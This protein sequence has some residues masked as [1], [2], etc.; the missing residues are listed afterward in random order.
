MVDGLLITRMRNL[1]I[2]ILQ[3]VDAG[4]PHLLQDGAVVG[5]LITWIAGAFT[6]DEEQRVP[7]R[8]KYIVVNLLKFVLVTGIDN[9]HCSTPLPKAAMLSAAISGNVAVA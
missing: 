8:L 6:L 9:S 3:T 2:D 7:M 1:H 5:T 4:P